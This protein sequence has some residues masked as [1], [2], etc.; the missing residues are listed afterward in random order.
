M[1]DDHTDDESQAARGQDS[2]VEDWFGQSVQR[3]A[4]LADEL[5]AAE[6]VDMDRVE[7]DFEKTARGK[8]EQERRHGEHID[9]DQG[10]SAYGG[11]PESPGATIDDPDPAEPNEPA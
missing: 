6:D 11:D 9:P 5:T 1:T 2:R 4:E 3:D 10:R 8:S 7:T